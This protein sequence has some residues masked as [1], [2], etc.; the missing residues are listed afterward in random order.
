MSN[1]EMRWIEPQWV[2][3]GSDETLQKRDI[4]SVSGNKTFPL[5][6]I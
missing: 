1:E 6:N 5:R 3:V 4:F 2:Q